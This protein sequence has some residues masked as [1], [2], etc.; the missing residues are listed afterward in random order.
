MRARGPAAAPLAALL[1]FALVASG[2]GTS[3]PS[4][5]VGSPSVDASGSPP[6][7]PELA[8]GPAAELGRLLA[9]LQRTH[10]E[11][12][13]SVSRDEFV[14]ALA[15]YEASLPSLTEDQA[16]VGLMRVVAMLSRN[17]RDGHQFALPIGEADGPIVPLRVYEFAEGVFVTDAMAPHEDLIGA[18]ITAIGGAA[19][20][21]VLEELEQ[22]IPRD[23]P[24]TVPAFRPIFL[25][26]A[27]VLRGLGIIGN[28]A[29][30]VSVED[31]SGSARTEE[32]EPIGLDAYVEWAGALGM[33]QLPADP[34]NP[35]LA[36]DEP[37]SWIEMPDGET[38]Y[39]RYRSVVAPDVA[40]VRERLAAGGVDRLILDLRQNP[41]GDN[42]TYPALLGLVRDFAAE[43]P[44]RLVVLTDR[45]TFSAAA[46]LATEIEQTTDATFIGEPMGGGLNFW[47]D[48]AWIELDELPVPM[49]VGISTRYWQKAAADDPRLSIDPD[50]AIEVTAADHFAGRDSALEAALGH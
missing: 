1:A 25:V 32:L 12:F 33:H 28:G 39:L 42:T 43:H 19:I 10:P 23:G 36:D 3:S 37:F 6:S 7:S 30:E 22:L 48:V 47:D 2:C 21:E 17:G 49:R 9:A 24:A 38:V 41:G 8:E 34:S 14:A 27:A 44:G 20:D 13:H 16:V 35:Y 50:I 18:R 4:D 15:A 5:D 46:N 40:P 45:V 29:V 11:P 31:A 26:R